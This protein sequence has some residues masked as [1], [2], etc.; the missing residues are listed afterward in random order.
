MKQ[1]SDYYIG[2][3]VR[4]RETFHSLMLDRH[5]L[6][7]GF[8][9]LSMAMMGYTLV[10]IFLTIGGG[11]PSTFEPW[12]AISKE[13]YYWYNRY[14]LAPSMMAGWILAAG[15][16]QLLCIF[17]PWIDGRGSF[18]DNL[19]VL[20]FGIGIASSISLLHD[21]P[22]TVLGAMG[23]IDLREYEVALNSPTIWRNILWIIYGLYFVVFLV[24]FPLGIATAQRIRF[25][26]SSI[27]VGWI[28]FIVYQGTFLIFNR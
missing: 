26:P 1:F 7:R 27:L 10:Y 2:V 19:S 5:R 11:A 16:A 8:Q 3:I 14:M 20:G 17:L 9:A 4:P 23:W 6:W 25:G 18:E 21:L 12:L 24:L 15:I 22:D 28:A 13:E